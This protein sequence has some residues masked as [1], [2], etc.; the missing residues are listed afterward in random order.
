MSKQCWVECNLGSITKLDIISEGKF[1][2]DWLHMKHLSAFN[3]HEALVFKPVFL[4]LVNPNTYKTLPP[5]KVSVGQ[6]PFAVTFLE[7][8]F[9]PVGLWLF[10]HPWKKKTKVKVGSWKPFKL[11][12]VLV[13]KSIYLK[14]IHWKI[15]HPII[16]PSVIP[17]VIHPVIQSHF[18][19]ASQLV[20]GS[21]YMAAPLAPQALLLTSYRF[22]GLGGLPLMSSTTSGGGATRAT[23]LKTKGWNSM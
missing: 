13:F 16:H 7:K 4:P 11:K 14:K 9:S 12:S 15:H 5:L 19:V 20:L 3:L 21:L 1:P 2:I 6:S 10:D 23:P 18:F 22:R 8:S 17:Y